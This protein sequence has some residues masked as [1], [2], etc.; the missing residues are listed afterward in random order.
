M[1]LRK[2]KSL[3][4][5]ALALVM[6]LTFVPGGA[7]KSLAADVIELTQAD[8]EEAYEANGTQTSKYISYESG[9]EYT[10]YILNEGRTYKLMDDVLL[11]DVEEEYPENVQIST[12]EDA[13]ID[14]NGHTLAAEIDFGGSSKSV[15]TGNGKLTNGGFYTS[16]TISDN[17]DVTVD[18]T[19][20]VCGI[21]VGTGEEGKKSKLTFNDVTFK[22]SMSVSS[23]TVIIDKSILDG[24]NSRGSANIYVFGNSSIEVNDGTFT[25]PDT[26]IESLG[27]GNTI[28]INKGKFTGYDGIRLNS[29]DKVVI[30]SGTFI[31]SNDS[32]TEGFGISI[33]GTEDTSLFGGLLADGSSYSPEL[34][35]SVLPNENLPSVHSQKEISVV[36]ASDEPAEYTVTYET[37]GGS[38]VK[39]ETVEEG[40][41]ATKPADP[42]KEGYKFDGWYADKDLK[43]AFD[44]TT[45]INEDT[46]VYAKWTE[47]KKEDTKED[48]KKEDT[49]EDDKKEDTKEDDKK[50]DTKVD[51]KKDDT[52]VDDK[53]DDT[54]VD[55]KK[56]VI[57]DVPEDAEEFATYDGRT[58]YETE[59]GDIIVTKA[60]G[61]REQDEFVCDGTYTYFVQFDGTVMKDRLSYHPDGEHVIYFDEDGHEVFNDFA[62]VKRS[63]AG[64]EVD[65]YC[66][67][68]VFG[69]MYVDV[70]TWDKTGTVLY[71]ANPYGV[72]EM[73]KWFQFSDT[74]VWGD[75]TPTEGIAG[76]YGYATENGT[77]MRDQATYDW[78]GKPCYMQGNG[79]ALY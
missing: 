1:K 17:A 33:T 5:F 29:D 22:G 62:H 57:P 42:T 10:G 61:E 26:G 74:V 68:D 46:T 39:A 58:F 45:A 24:E 40:K 53:K 59:D 47:D 73:N 34:T 30:V 65:D 63:I 72:M 13:T 18:N 64:E 71:Y 67:F 21:S 78:E 66:F 79:V 16:L 20:I 48:D 55:D 7:I 69:H 9:A 76:G 75:G 8:F 50:D 25:S 36:N 54:K 52:K 11:V 2:K 51:D 32:E 19:T 15:I 44:F 14:L 3:L 70:I 12:A 31:S 56:E 43:T 6:A 28:T 49:K 41:T 37:N 77:L 23:G 38:T 4:S 35:A 27:T 60:N